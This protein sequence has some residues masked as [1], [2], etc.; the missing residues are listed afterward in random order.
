MLTKVVYNIG[1]GSFTI[2][3][4]ALRRMQE[5]GF[6]GDFIESGD[7][8][9][10]HL[11]PRHNPFLIQAVEELGEKANGFSS[12]LKIAQVFGPYRI[13][14]YDGSETVMEPDDY[15]WTTP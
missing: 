5:L 6:T 4:E 13:E 12:D 15:E 14:E 7:S 9:W 3:H 11:C 8:I 2:S 1:D 10:L